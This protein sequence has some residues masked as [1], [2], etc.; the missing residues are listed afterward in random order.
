M[1]H[2][3]KE[4]FLK[5]YFFLLDVSQEL[6]QLKFSRIFFIHRNCRKLLLINLLRNLTFKSKQVFY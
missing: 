4:K 1:K 3:D 2:I 6:V 5:S